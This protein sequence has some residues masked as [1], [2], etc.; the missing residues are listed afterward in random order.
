MPSGS[1][2]SWMAPRPERI[3]MKKVEVMS[4]CT[5]PPLR[6]DQDEI[7]WKIAVP[8][9]NSEPGDQARRG[10]GCRTSPRAASQHEARQHGGTFYVGELER[11]QAEHCATD[12]GDRGGQGEDHDLRPGSRRWPGPRPRP[13]SC[14]RRVWQQLDDER[15]SAWTTRVRNPNTARNSRICS[16]SR[17]KSILG[18]W[19]TPRRSTRGSRRPIGDFSLSQLRPGRRASG[20][21]NGP[22]R[23]RRC[24]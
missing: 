23:S 14:A 8:P 2:A 9:A 20:Q 15:I 22:A 18:R 3:G 19:A 13:P 12:T 6:N 5:S 16:W 21:R 24:G 7:Q 17:L 11:E 1:C 10:G 4:A